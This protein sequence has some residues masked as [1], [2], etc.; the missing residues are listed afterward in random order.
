MSSEYGIISLQNILTIILLDLKT[1]TTLALLH[2]RTLYIKYSVEI[3]IINSVIR[4]R[5]TTNCKAISSALYL[6]THATSRNLVS[7][8]QK[9]RLVDYRGVFFR[10]QGTIN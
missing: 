3:R 10:F 7:I 1:K 9:F 8:I 4:E 5:L 2:W 6:N